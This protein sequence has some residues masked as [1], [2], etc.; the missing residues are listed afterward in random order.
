MVST[1][2][3]SRCPVQVSHGSIALLAGALILVPAA[4]LSQDESEAFSVETRAELEG[5]FERQPRRVESIDSQALEERNVETLGDAMAW[6]S[7]ATAIQPAGTATGVQVDG[8]PA[9][10]LTVLRD[11]VPISR[12]NGSPSG[13][14]VDVDSI[15]VDPDTVERIEVYRG[16]GPGQ[17]GG[18]VVNIVTRS[19]AEAPGVTL[20]GTLGAFDD[21]FY[22]RSANLSAEA[23]IGAG[24][25][26]G[27]SGRIKQRNEVDVNQDGRAD[28]P[29]RNDHGA[30]LRLGWA[31]DLNR[32]TAAFEF[33][34]AETWSRGGANAPL[35]DRIDSEEYRTRITGRW[36]PSRRVQVTHASDFGRIERAFSKHVRESGF[37]RLKQRTSDLQTR[38]RAGLTYFFDDH[39]LGGEA[40]LSL[41]HVE[42]TGE[43]GTLDPETLL[44][45]GLSL[46][47]RWYASDR[48]EIHGR[49]RGAYARLYG[50]GLSA[51]LGAAYDLGAG[52]GVRSSVART[53]RVPTAEEL[54]LF[55]DHSEVGY[56]I[57][58]NPALQPEILNSVRAGTTFRDK[59]RGLGVE[60][61][62]FG[63]VIQDGIVTTSLEGQN[64]LFRSENSGE[65][66]TA[67]INASMQLTDIWGWAGVR[68]SYT[69]LPVARDLAQDQDLTLRSTHSARFEVRGDWFSDRLHARTT[70]QARSA[71]T[72][73]EGSP[74]APA[75][76]L[77][78]SG[79]AWRFLPDSRIALDVENLLD[80]TNAT[81]G[82]VPGF[83]G[84]LSLS[85]STPR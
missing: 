25:W 66:L 57:E 36:W 81:W 67:G 30:T 45:V 68:A 72:V 79:V 69:F 37:D 39:E 13:P 82:P 27:A 60:F 32:L 14:L 26:I 6:I 63:H 34:E 2:S 21:S 80:Q 56:R 23:P 8:L 33:D 76:A 62:G 53:R 50:T 51:E 64:D 1:T 78:S 9:G 70:V 4:A 52:F 48:L 29:E 17:S 84:M 41:N 54:F 20:R 19:G 12:A 65:L 47:E 49:V 3:A 55:F 15:P 85:I 61:E 42:R 10:Q 73:P 38:Q 59:D 44:E 7:G 11:G 83:Y 58:G 16:L 28:T 75:Y 35:D 71:L 24:F 40:D 31:R 77:V 46:D 22:R 5:A 74:G 43:T 18:V